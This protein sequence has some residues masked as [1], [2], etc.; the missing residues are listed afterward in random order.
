MFDDREVLENLYDGLYLVTRLR[1]ITFW[2]RAA[3]AITGYSA[4]E[5]MGLHCYAGPLKHVDSDGNDLCAQGCPLNWAM[6]HRRQHLADIFLHHKEGHRIPVRVKVSPLYNAAGE[7]IGAAEL[8]SD[9]TETMLALER[10]GELEETALLD[11]LTRLANKDYLESQTQRYLRD[12]VRYPKHIGVLLIELDDFE[13]VTAKLSI[14]ERKGLLRVIAETIRSNCRPMDL[15][16]HVDEGCFV[17]LIHDVTSNQLFTIGQKLNILIQKSHF[18][19]GDQLISVKASIGGTILHIDDTFQAAV[20]RC[21]R[22][23]QVAREK[24]SGVSVELRFIQQQTTF[25]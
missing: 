16:G 15:F 17:G 11:P 10:L 1:K 20:A 7:A 2:N 6:A 13:G 8:F 18:L 24:T 4:G 21:E 25:E 19:Q 22:Q 3:E 14:P 12:M 9:N 5:V 23:L